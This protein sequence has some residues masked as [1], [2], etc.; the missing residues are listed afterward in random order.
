MKSL[1]KMIRKYLEKRGWVSRG[2]PVNYAKSIVIEAAEL[3]ELF[4][5]S[6]PSISTLK[7]NKTRFEAVKKEL[8]DI[9]I[10]GFDLA[11]TLGLDAEKLVREKMAYNIKKYPAEFVKSNLKNYYKI[12]QQY[13]D[14][15]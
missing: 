14:K 3:L 1:Q 15:K 2:T 6:N 12:K 7:K 4:Q 10:Y 11:E 8:A 5:W 13:R 9:F